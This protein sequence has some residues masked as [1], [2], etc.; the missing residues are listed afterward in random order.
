MDLRVPRQLLPQRVHR[1]L[2]V[3]LLV[4]VLL[5]DVRVDLDCLNVLVLHVFLE[6]MGNGILQLQRVADLVNCAVDRILEAFYMDI[7]CSNLA[8]IRLN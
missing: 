4:L 1:V 7:I 5:L 3:L 6:K 8:P 2:Q